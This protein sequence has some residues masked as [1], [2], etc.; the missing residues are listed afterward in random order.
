ML[1]PPAE[2]RLW[3]THLEQVQENRK[4]GAE[5]AAEKRRLKKQTK[6]ECYYYFGVCHEQYFEYTEL[7]RS[8]LHV[9]AVILGITLVVLD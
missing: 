7:C 3:F 8:G 5:K 9:T 4:R 1:L 2:V 6:D